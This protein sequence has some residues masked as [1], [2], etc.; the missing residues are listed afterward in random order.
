MMSVAGLAALGIWVGSTVALRGTAPAPLPPADGIISIAVDKP[1]N[2]FEGH[3]AVGAGADGLEENEIDR[4]W[5]TRNVEAM[6]SAGFGPLSYRLRTELGVKAWHWNPRGAWSQPDQEQGYWTSSSEPAEDYGVSYGYRLPRRGNT[7]DQGKNNG[8]SRLNDGDVETFWKSN[9]YLD[10]HFTGEPDSLHPQWIMAEFPQ[11]VPVDTVRFDWGTPYATRFKVQY[12]TGHD[13]RF[14][15]DNGNWRD[16]PQAAHPGTG[17]TQTARIASRPLDVQYLRILLTEDSDAAPAGSRDVRDRL[18]VAVREIYIGQQ[19][20]GSFVDHVRHTK[21]HGQTVMWTSSTDPW[22]REEDI[23]KNYEHASFERIFASGITKGE[24]MMV[25]VP[26]LYGT[27]DD[28][29]A[30]ARYLGKRG[31]PVQRVEIGE[32]PNGRLASRST[33]G[34]SMS[35]WPPP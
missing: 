26:A 9:P 2:K 35:R 13:A 6:K 17:G 28:A 19:Q 33:T 16:F 25:P 15:V 7:V 14:P 11:A 4:V 23:D 12:W 20:A 29:A 21:S 10:S 30:L 22:H 3:R 31:Y 32:E 8:H 18:G 24:P 27:P 34:R 5:S 1:V